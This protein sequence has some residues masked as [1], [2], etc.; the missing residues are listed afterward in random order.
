MSDP[1]EAIAMPRWGLAMEEGTL[2]EWLVAEGDNLSA[3][4][5]VVEIETTKITNVFESPVGGTLRR[6]VTA[7]GETVPVGALL[8]VVAD[9]SVPDAD[10][11]AFV[12]EFNAKFEAEA[13]EAEAAAPEPE[14][15][16][17]GGRQINYLSQGEGEGPPVVMLHGFGGDLNGW[18]FN[19]PALAEGRRVIALDLPGHGRSTKDVGGG[20]MA[21]M[22]ATLVDFMDAL[23]IQQ[24]HLVGHSMGGALGL[25][26]ALDSPSRVASLT[27]LA[28]AGLGPEINMDFIEGFIGAGRR[29]EMKGVLQLLV[30]D[31]ALVSRDMIEDVLKFK[32][33]DG[34]DAGLRRLAEGL[35]PGGRQDQIPADGL[36]SLA[37]P[38][39]AIWGRDDKIVPADHADALPSAV[40]VH[41]LDGIGHMP[42]MEAAAEVNR[43]IGTQLG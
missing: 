31:P 13:A 32:R 16:S 36:A 7:A 12:T 34:V 29:K 37:V 40:T 33:L 38:A 17:A 30:A 23:N 1:I 3:G 22:S 8:G 11:D 41:L 26:F 39:Q 10:I 42:H 20:T 18:L 24:A 15:V 4:D 25:A 9:P 43:L 35:F 6:Q 27:L 28:P 21:D 5:E 2:V 14:V 19:Q